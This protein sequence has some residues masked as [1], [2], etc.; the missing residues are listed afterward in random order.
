MFVWSSNLIVSKMSSNNNFNYTSEANLSPAF[1]QQASTT[2]TTTSTTTTELPA[3][4]QSMAAT[5]ALYPSYADVASGSSGNINAGKPILFG[6]PVVHHERT[7]PLTL[8]SGRSIPSLSYH[9]HATTS[10]AS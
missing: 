6:P 9:H 2:T 5:T 7:T 8:P 1:P 10:L 3:K 4:D